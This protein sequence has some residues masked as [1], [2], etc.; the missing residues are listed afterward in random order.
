MNTVYQNNTGYHGL[1][2]ALHE[3]GSLFVKKDE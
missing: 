3:A 2:K 1:V